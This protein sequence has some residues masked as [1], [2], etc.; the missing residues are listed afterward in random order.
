MYVHTVQQIQLSIAFSKNFWWKGRCKS[1]VH[2]AH[3]FIKKRESLEIVLPVVSVSDDF[4]EEPVNKRSRIKTPNIQYTS[5]YYKMCNVFYQWYNGKTTTDRKE[6]I[7]KDVGVSEN[8]SFNLGRQASC[9]HESIEPSLTLWSYRWRGRGALSPE[10]KLLERGIRSSS[11]EVNCARD[12][13]STPNIF[14]A[15]R[16]IMY[17]DN[18]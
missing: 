7:W 17:S 10:I 6:R 1:S 14:K 8:T 15:W 12:C 2:H 4:K 16:T 11:T 9:R 3:R 18:F 13:T 5:V